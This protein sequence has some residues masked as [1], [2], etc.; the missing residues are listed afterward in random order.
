MRRAAGKFVNQCLLRYSSFQ[1][2]N[3][4]VEIP[5]PQHASDVGDPPSASCK[6]PMIAPP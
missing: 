6:I 2:Q 3:V 1:L 4:A 5:C